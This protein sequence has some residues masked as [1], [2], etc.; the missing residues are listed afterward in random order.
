MNRASYLP[1]FSEAQPGR[2]R[3][4]EMDHRD[5]HDVVE[6]LPIPVGEHRAWNYT[7]D[8]GAIRDGWNEIAIYNESTEELSVVGVELGL[9]RNNRGL[10]GLPLSRA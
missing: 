7:L 2:L 9:V 5:Q 6:D 3:K 10:A 1:V 4:A 8:C